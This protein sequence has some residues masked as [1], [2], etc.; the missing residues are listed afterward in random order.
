VDYNKI[1]SL[2]TVDEVLRL[3]PFA[4]KWRAFGWRV[5]EA[6]GHDVGVLAKVLE[7][8]PGAGKPACVVAHTVKGKGVSF[9]ENALLWHYRAPD[10][11][12]LNRALAEI[13]SLR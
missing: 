13:G 9:M 7:A 11:A 4:E 6:D 1:Q 10:A 2:G 3:E 8:T 5:T 12:E